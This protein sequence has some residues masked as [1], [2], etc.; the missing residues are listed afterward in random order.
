[1][2]AASSHGR[3]GPGSRPSASEPPGVGLPTGPAIVTAFGAAT[4]LVVLGLSVPK[5]TMWAA[6]LFAS[7]VV[8]IAGLLLVV[9]PA[10]DEPWL[11]ALEDIAP[12]V[13][14]AFL[15]SGGGELHAQ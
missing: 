11:D 13:Q 4:A 6:A 14:T 12:P 15:S 10:M 1:M 9:F 7:V 5:L 3:S 8:A 2:A